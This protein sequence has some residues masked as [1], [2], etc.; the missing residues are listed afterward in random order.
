MINMTKKLLAKIAND[1]DKKSLLQLATDMK[2]PYA[3]LWRLVNKESMGT[4]KT[5]EKISKYY[6]HDKK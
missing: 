4:I 6:N 3:T 1:L 2:M 5:W